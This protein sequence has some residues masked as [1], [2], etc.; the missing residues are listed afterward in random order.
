MEMRKKKFW[1]LGEQ[2]CINI[3]ESGRLK[4]AEELG[5]ELMKTSKRLLGTEHPEMPTSTANL[6]STY[7]HRRAEGASNGD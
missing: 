1:S 3:T 7:H 2:S 6:A 5:V 4:E